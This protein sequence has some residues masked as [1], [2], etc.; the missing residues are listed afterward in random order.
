MSSVVP[1][2]AN[3]GS[4]DGSI[5][6]VRAEV[7]VAIDVS[8]RGRSAQVGVFKFLGA[9]TGFPAAL[10]RRAARWLVGA[11]TERQQNWH[12]LPVGPL[13][14][15]EIEDALAAAV[16]EFRATIAELQQAVT[17]MKQQMGASEANKALGGSGGAT[18]PTGPNKRKTGR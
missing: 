18:S 15:D 12:A 5:I 6:I 1:R 14:Y 10:G 16:P 11:V 4:S 8:T 17:N 2:P 3:G 7:H 13:R 9:Q